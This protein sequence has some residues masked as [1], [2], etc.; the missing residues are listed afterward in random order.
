[1]SSIQMFIVQSLWVSY[2]ESYCIL[3]V[4]HLTP[5]CSTSRVE[6]IKICLFFMHN[7]VRWSI[8]KVTKSKKVSNLSQISEISLRA[9]SEPRE[10]SVPGTLLEMVAGRTTI[11]ILNSGNLSRFS[12]R[13]RAVWKACNKF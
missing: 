12:A 6:C 2:N 13:S 1:M 4:K 8:F 7:G 10:K 9:V 5:K 11:G 3:S